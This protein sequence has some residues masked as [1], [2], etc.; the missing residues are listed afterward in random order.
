[1]D[2]IY[3]NWGFG[4]KTPTLMRPSASRLAGALSDLIGAHADL[5]DAQANVPS[6][7]AQWSA[8]DYTAEAQ[9]KYN[10]AADAFEDALV[11]SVHARGP[12]GYPCGRAVEAPRTGSPSKE[13]TP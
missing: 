12:R 10:R 3:E 8:A 2:D 5:M 11:A 13:T 6:Y 9:E 1:M 4:G 7:T